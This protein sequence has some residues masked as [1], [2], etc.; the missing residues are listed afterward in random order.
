MVDT[1]SPRGLTIIELLVAM[2]VAGM[3]SSLL[4][5][6]LTSSREAARKMSC[7]NNLKQIG[8]AMRTYHHTYLALPPTGTYVWARQ[9]NNGQT[10]SSSSH[11]S[12]WSKL[13]PFMEHDPLYNQLNHIVTGLRQENPFRGWSRFEIDGA[14]TFD[15]NHVRSEVLPAFLCPSAGLAPL[16]HRSR[17]EIDPTIITYGYSIGAQKCPSWQNICTSFP[18]NMFGT[19]PSPHGTDGRAFTTSGVFSNGG[20]AARFRDITD[21]ESQVILGGETL[22][23]KSDHMQKGWLNHHANFA[24]TGGPINYPVVGIGDSGFSWSEANPPLNPKNCSHFKNWSTS[25]GFKSH[26]KGGAQFIF[27]DGGVQFLAEDID[28]ITYNRLGC[29]RDGVP[30]RDWLMN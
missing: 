7:S 30:I 26:H 1:K 5:G 10:W 16:L 2:A 24:F 17:S 25:A 13:L 23:N 12:V 4:L 9:S 22:P 21:G 19:G 18:G 28:Y 6:G 15:G 3:L 20:W 14:T 11:G 27:C 8:L 29:R